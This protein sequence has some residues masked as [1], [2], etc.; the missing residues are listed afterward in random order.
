M[1]K[2]KILILGGAGYIG[3][4]LCNYLVN[5]KYD[6]TCIDTF[7]FGDYLNKKVKK[8]KK[9]IN[10]FKIPNVNY[11]V[12]IN[13]AYLSNDPLCEMDARLTWESGPL[14][15]YKLLE[16]LKKNKI[17]RFIF[18]SSGSIYGLKKE[19]F[20]T[21]KLG[22]D[23][24]TDYNKS[25]MICE[26]VIESYS[27]SISST[28]IRPA[29]VCGFSPRLRLDTV[30]NMFCYQAFFNK[31]IKI[32]GG[33]QTR[34]L[35]HIMD[36]VRTYEFFINRNVSGCFNLGF[37]NK[38]VKEL[39]LMVKKHIPCKVSTY[40]SNDIRSYRISSN[41][42]KKIGFVE[43]FNANDAILEFKERFNYFKPSSENWNLKWLTKKKVF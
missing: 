13:L 2:K 15:T 12:V 10:D 24:I 20:V 16:S 9:N 6:I 17:K 19:K 31:K 18:A 42:I 21:E 40:K 38:S 28:I 39:A 30:L 23:P 25:K 7:W 1:K 32:F 4:V 3:T 43:K 5:K 8:I 29:T 22:L 35:V 27:D 11:D 26:K 34:P 33:K 14:A 36:M 37:E 41:K